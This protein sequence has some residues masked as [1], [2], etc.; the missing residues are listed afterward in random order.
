MSLSER[1]SMTMVTIGPVYNANLY[2]KYEIN[3]CLLKYLGILNYGYWVFD[4]F[5]IP[6]ISFIRSPVSTAFTVGATRLSD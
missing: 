3:A 1:R 4:N 2:T 5:V 6:C